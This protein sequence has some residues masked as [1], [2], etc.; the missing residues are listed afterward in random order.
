MPNGTTQ[1]Q[2]G[3]TGRIA[4]ETDLA[5][6]DFAQQQLNAMQTPIFGNF[7]QD[8][9]VKVYFVLQDGTRNDAINDSHLTNV[10]ILKD[11]LKAIAETNPNI[12]VGYTPGSG[13]EG[14]GVG[15]IDAITGDS[16]DL[17]I[18]MAY[19]DFAIQVE[20]WKAENPDVKVRVINVNFSRGSAEAAGL[21]QLIDRIGVIDPDNIDPNTINQQTNIN[22]PTLIQPN[23]IAQ[24]VVSFDPVATGE[25][26]HRDLIF[27]DSV[28][29]GFQINAGDEFRDLFPVTNLIGQGHTFDDKFLG[30]TTA[31]AHTDIGGS[32]LDKFLSNMN[33]NL[34]ATYI[35]SLFE[36]PILSPVNNPS[37]SDPIVHNSAEHKWIYKT[38]DA[39]TEI[40]D[41]NNDLDGIQKVSDRDDSLANQFTYRTIG[42][43]GRGIST[44]GQYKILSEESWEFTKNYL[45]NNLSETD[46]TYFQNAKGE[47]FVAIKEEKLLVVDINNDAYLKDASVSLAKFIRDNNSL[48]AEENTKN[49]FQTVGT[50]LSGWVDSTADFIKSAATSVGNFFGGEGNA[51]SKIGSLVSSVFTNGQS[52]GTVN[53]SLIDN[54]LLNLTTQFSETSHN[55]TANPD[56]FING[57]ILSGGDYQLSMPSEI[58]NQDGFIN[59]LMSGTSSDS[60]RPGANT[61]TDT[62]LTLDLDKITQNLNQNLI[63]APIPTPDPTP[64]PGFFGSIWNGIKD[65]FSQ[66]TNLFTSAPEVQNVDPVILDLNN[67]G[68]ELISYDNSTVSFNVDNDE[69]I[70]HTG[71]VKGTDGILVHDKNND[72][73]INDIKETISEYYNP[74]NSNINPIDDSGRYF[75]DGLEALKSLDSNHDNIF[76]NQ[77]QDWNTLRVWQDV[78]EDGITDAGEL[79]TLDSLNIQSI[80]L[81]RT[82][83]H[84]ERIEG[85]PILAR[86]SMTMNDGTTREVAAIDFATNP[87]GYEWND[88]YEQGQQIGAT[89]QTEDNKSS[90]YVI[91]TGTA[92]VAT[93]AIDLAQKGVNSAYGNI[94]DDTL[95]GD[96]KDNWLM[97]GKGSDTLTGGAGDD[98]LIID[99]EDK[100]ENINAGA[101]KDFIKVV[102]DEAI[103]FNMNLSQAEVIQS[104][105]GDDVLIG[106]G[107]SNV[108][109]NAGAGDDIIIGGAADDALSGEDG[110]D[111]IDGGYG[112]DV[113]RGHRG[114]DLLIG[115]LGGDYIDGGADNDIIQGGLGDDVLIGGS[116]NDEIDGGAGFDMVEYKGKYDQYSF[117]KASDGTVTVVDT[118]NG[119]VDIIKNVEKLRFDNVNFNLVG[120]EGLPLPV[121]DNILIANDNASLIIDPSQILANDFNISGKALHISEVSDAVGG[122]VILRADGKIEFTPDP[123]FIGTRSFDYAVADEDGFFAT[124][125]RKNADGTIVQANLKAQVNLLNQSDPSDPLYFDQWYLSEIKLKNVW[126]EYSGQGVNIGIFEEN[127]GSPLNHNHQ[128]L[129]DNISDDYLN[130]T[131]LEDDINNFS[132]HTTLVAGVIAAEKNGEGAVG[133]AYNSKIASHS[134]SPDQDGLMNLMNYDV[135]N[136]SWGNSIAFADDFKQDMGDFVY[137]KET[138]RSF[139]NATQIGRDGLGTSIVFAGGNSRAEGDNVN[140]HNI[141][142]SRQVITTGSINQDGDLSKLVEAS[143]PF[144]NPGSAILVSAPGSNIKSTANLI[145]NSNGSTF[146]SDFESTQGTSFSAPIVSGVVALMMEA[147]PNLGYRDVQ[148][149]LA[150]T[151]RKV[152]DANTVWKNNGDNNVNGGGGMH[153]SE[154]YGFGIVDAQNAVRLAEVWG[155]INN[156]NNEQSLEFS[157]NTTQNL[158]D[159]GA[160]N[161]VINVSASNLKI[162]YAEVEVNIDH[163]RIGDLVITLISPNG[164]QSILVNRAGKAPGSG[165]SDLGSTQNG[166]KFTFSTTHNYGENGVG[167]WILKIEDKVLGTTGVLNDWNLKLYGSADNGDDDYFFAEEYK[168]SK[169]LND[170]DGGVDNIYATG[171]LTNSTI[172][173]N[174]GQ[175][176]NINGV[177]LTIGSGS[178]I[179]NAYAGEG[180]DTVIGNTAGNIL[181]GGKGNN[182]LTGGGGNDQFL[183]AKNAGKTDII[184]DFAVTNP[185]EKI[186]LTKFGFSSF[187]NLSI[188]QSGANAVIDLGLGQKLILQNVTASSLNANN[189]SGL[190]N[191]QEILNGTTANDNLYGSGQDSIIAAG[192]GDDYI[193]GGKGNNILNGGA[194]AD[195][196]FIEVNAGKTDTITDFDIDQ[197]SDEKI[198]LRNF[199]DI[200]NI[201]DLSIVQ[202]GSDVE[203]LL[204][205]GQKIILKNTNQSDLS[206]SNFIFFGEIIGTDGADKMIGSDLP[207]IMSGGVGDDVLKGLDW[208]DEIDGGL[209]DDIIRGDHGDDI[210]KG[211]FGKDSIIGGIGADTIYGGQD[212][213][214]L[215]GGNDVAI[216]SDD[217]MNIIYGDAGNDEIYGDKGAD[218]LYGGM[219]VDMI[220]GAD[221]DDEIDG[222]EGNDEIYGE[223][224]DD[225]ILG[226]DGDDIIDG[227]IG[228][229]EIYGGSGNDYIE[230]ASGTN[231]IYGDDGDDLI[232][233]GDEVDTI[234]GGAGNDTIVGEN[235]NAATIGGGDFIYGE[236]GN[237][238]LLGSAGND[239]IYGGNNNDILQGDLGSDKL[240]GGS[241]NDVLRG[242]QGNNILTGGS[243]SDVFVIDNNGQNTDI[244]TDFNLNDSAEKINLLNLGRGLDFNQLQITQSGLDAVVNLANNQKIILK[245]INKSNLNA[246][247]FITGNSAPVVVNE[248][249]A[250]RG[251]INAPF[252][253][254]VQNT[255][256]DAD[257]DNLT[258]RATLADGSALPSWLNFD[259]A[260]LTFSNNGTPTQFS[261][262]IK[263]TAS[264][265]YGSS[266]STNFDFVVNNGVVINGTTGNDFSV[267]SIGNDYITGEL[268]N[269]YL[270]GNAGDD[271]IHGGVGND[272][273]RGDVSASYNPSTGVISTSGYN[274]NIGNDILYGNAGNDVILGDRGNDEIYGGAGDDTILG[275]EGNDEIYGGD[276]NDLLEGG[277]DSDPAFSG[278]DGDKIYG[279]AGNDTIYAANGN[280][281]IYGDEGDDYIFGYGG[282][283][284]IY[285]GAGKDTVFGGDGN[286]IIHLQGGNQLINFSGSLDTAFLGEA[287]N[288]TFVIY[289]DNSG[290]AGTGILNDI[291]YDFEVNNPNEKIDLTA[292]KNIR[293]ISDLSFSNVSLNGAAFLRVYVAG[294]ESS[295]Y[296][297]LQ[298]ITKNQLSNSN[299]IFFND[300]APIAGN[301]NL[302]TNEDSSIT[303]K[304]S[305][306]MLNDNDVESIPTFLRIVTNPLNGSFVNNND[307]TYTYTPL[308]NFKGIDSF[309]YQIKDGNGAIRSATVNINIASVNDAPTA[310]SFTISIQ[311][312]HSTSID[313]LSGSTDIDGN[314][315]S[316][317][318]IGNPAH[319]NASIILNATGKQIISYTPNGNYNGV[320][321][322]E[323][324]ISDGQG[325]LVTKTITVNIAS[326]NDVPTVSVINVSVSEDN[327]LAT[328][329]FLGNDADFDDQLTYSLVSTPSKGLV[330]NNNDGTFSFNTNGQFE[331]LKAGEVQNL[332]FYYKTTDSTGAQSEIA[333]INIQVIGTNDAPTATLTLASTNED[334]KTI[335]DVLASA[336][337][338]DGD[339]LTISAITNPSHGIAEII[340]D[341]QGKQIISYI[342]NGNYNGTDSFNYVISDGYGAM[343]TKTLNLQINSIND[344]PIATLLS[345]STNEDTT[346]I[347]DVLASASDVDGNALIISAITNP[348]HGTATIITNPQT[349]YQTIS[350]IPSSNYNGT[351][352]L[353]YTISDGNG[354]LVTKTLTLTIDPINQVVGT[355]FSDYLRT[356]HIFNTNNSSEITTNKILGLEG[357][358]MIN[359]FGGNDY[360]DGG[361]GNDFIVVGSGTNKL[362]G[363]QGSDIFS[364]QISNSSTDNS[365]NTIQDFEINN[366]LEKI[367]LRN[368]SNIKQLS[369]LNLTQ[370]GNDVIITLSQNNKIT[371]KNINQDSLQ[372][373]N[374]I[375]HSNHIIG[376][377]FDDEIYPGRTPYPAQGELITIEGKNGD[378]KLFTSYGHQNRYILNGGEGNDEL[379]SNDGELIGGSGNDRFV[380]D[381]FVNPYSPSSVQIA[382]IDDLELDNPNEKIVIN[383]MNIH[384]FSDLVISQQGSD[385]NIKIG[386][387]N[388]QIL[389]KNTLASDL[390]ADNFEIHFFSHDPNIGYSNEFAVING[391]IEGTQTGEIISSNY[392]YGD[393]VAEINGLGGNDSISSQGYEDNIYGG[394]GDDNLSFIGSGQSFNQQNTHQKQAV[395]FYGQEGNDT[396]FSNNNDGF[397]NIMDG[398][399]GDDNFM[400]YDGSATLIGGAG[401]DSFAI[402]RSANSVVTIEDFEINNLRELIDLTYD[403]KEINNLNDLHLEQSGSDTILNLPDNQ[404]IILKNINKNDLTAENFKLVIGNK[405]QSGEISGS[406]KS[407]EINGGAGDDI[408]DAKG[409]SDQISGG[410]GVDRFIIA[411]DSGAVDAITDFDTSNEKIV[412]KGFDNVRSFADLNISYYVDEYNY[413]PKYYAVIKLGNN[414]FLK[415]KNITEHNPLSSGNFI[416]E[417]INQDQDNHDIQNTITGTDAKD[418]LI[419]TN[420]ND[421]ISGGA[422]ADILYG[423]LGND[424]LLG[425]SSDD[426]L[427]GGIGSDILDGGTAID[428]ASYN[429]SNASVMVN[430]QL[431][432]NINNPNFQAAQGG[433]AQG[434]IL[435]NIEN[436]TGSN[437]NDNLTGN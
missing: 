245:N 325:G 287:G 7:S 146:G 68:I 334:T 229:N 67:N 127:Y 111:M 430:L 71:W 58:L 63:N 349:G 359:S 323:Y 104:G 354:G 140:Y 317:S 17:G 18:G 91:T 10:G 297:S 416:F 296:I 252:S 338:I 376:S 382:T 241:G 302:S 364:F 423:G 193:N 255:F 390:S 110:N 393:Y 322:F 289:K 21:T 34:A 203:I 93:T 57:T 179:E 5:S 123:Y 128:D 194:G 379:H 226:A 237:D 148:K 30:V 249:P 136:N 180:N 117:S 300:R 329:S 219:G 3:I 238:S 232:F 113:I 362:I 392:P 52:D 107:T 225:K 205:D 6:Y 174:G 426:I 98:V 149:I 159:N 244:I 45:Y 69:F 432:T 153:Y 437:F 120:T 271:I 187:T 324:T 424:T 133:I 422:N 285:D 202:Q 15:T 261:G 367:D 37:D 165:A 2:D 143:D 83:T 11:Q 260:T 160:I 138:Q 258:Y 321:S 380:I 428:A 415:I 240:D 183:I 163:A 276:G 144:S 384:Q 216:M 264:D 196:F 305:D 210:L 413:I 167:N 387:G 239:E 124:V 26:Q 106:G 12:G 94:G 99:A 213:D 170:T 79:K 435:I 222:G 409:G 164:T 31:G 335:I 151:A 331:N 109:I 46:A 365:D 429:D 246:D 150:I 156:A 105:G 236:D 412:L 358:D 177:N 360:I 40:D 81:N 129:N 1:T 92:G 350:Y 192:D 82:I 374:F 126:Q 169:T 119:D 175:N 185:N 357:D 199:R 76:N 356:D 234:Y 147:N 86:S 394:E 189:F 310:H 14:R 204:N 332:S 266:V 427:I 299:F 402:D 385:T 135:A 231:L 320:D 35:N 220:Y 66:L 425:G 352:S 43:E 64:Q 100:N 89:I 49:W 132:N 173:L 369:D 41:L 125:S 217:K 257:G 366:P 377:E 19:R 396:F 408:I 152:E 372:E 307:G 53:T 190:L 336:S 259:P 418:T 381:D 223:E 13:T 326:V 80:D 65:G 268:G 27:A 161:S 44:A 114:E 256:L 403:F 355:Q 20:E 116:G 342:P 313:V 267:G 328:F 29:S 399:E 51:I 388:N 391:K 417:P 198:S 208:N 286:D 88:V 303:I 207:D 410:S 62:T 155:K 206:N 197:N 327:N 176:S 158:V 318:S 84:R 315:L 221:G 47:T 389:L 274:T 242:N 341:G 314:I 254:S 118:T 168:S 36:E 25:G 8:P 265:P 16:Y 397:V 188:T 421:Q 368:F 233:G 273:I 24:A 373:Y 59:N 434:D 54:S 108:F 288:D 212:D 431:N 145:E 78:N 112:D 270:F 295:Q 214:I 103:T 375:F 23:T 278:V 262:Q 279:G 22:A 404:K 378:D 50:A 166:L 9:N 139:D 436:I 330:I 75:A 251:F 370:N 195:T 227:G 292:F 154:D 95:I 312:D 347:I 90:S 181:Y 290:L 28:I 281:S 333:A 306:L 284:T 383:S 405:D 253:F 60:I 122:T 361:L 172:N 311:E 420:L 235:D 304:I 137:F 411:K 215:I 209:G 48:T 308:A 248:I 70:E 386:N 186:N 291:I 371:L 178:I 97:G 77:D 282:D 33:F 56:D 339:V 301:D 353:T 201:D 96:A 171:L 272:N 316:I 61:L 247:D 184:T 343:V 191:Q 42:E 134:W 414:Q 340:L 211:G 309:S 294:E 298:N 142:N 32:Y 275:C 395:H 115:G 401:S 398:G 400:I 182:T 55:A 85:N 243:G 74:N 345:S 407:E 280:D 72:G 337:D 250:K 130:D 348:A 269:D 351:D 419:G 406:N 162:E 4:N 87:I 218:K 200:K 224:G 230:V 319:G 277:A 39:R 228:N 344:M 157:K 131:L 102:G 283:D 363:G 293:D 38:L 101:G 121:K 141:Q 433:T 73:I 263:I 346:K